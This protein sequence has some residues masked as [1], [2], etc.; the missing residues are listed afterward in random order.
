M[1]SLSFAIRLDFQILAQIPLRHALD[2]L[3]D[4]PEVAPDGP[5]EQ[6][7]SRQADDGREQQDPQVQGTSRFDRFFDRF[8]A[9]FS[10]R[11]GHL[12]AL[13]ERG[14]ERG[15]PGLGD[16]QGVLASAFHV[17][18]QGALESDFLGFEEGLARSV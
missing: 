18:L 14:H 8:V 12:E 16:R 15:E 10:P 9:F 2:C 4:G 11:I 13:V 17:T 1:V 5:C 3:S 6:Q 7:S